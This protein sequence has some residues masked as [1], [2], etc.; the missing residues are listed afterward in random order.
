MSPELGIVD[1]DTTL[2]LNKPELQ[3]RIDRARAADLQVET[4][5][6]ATALRRNSDTKLIL[7]WIAN[8]N[9]R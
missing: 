8:E 7:D 9:L 2:R 5:D 1:A 3:V 6:I 4:Q